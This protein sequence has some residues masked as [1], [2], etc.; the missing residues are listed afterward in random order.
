MGKEGGAGRPLAAGNV[1]CLGL[2]PSDVGVDIRKIHRA[3]HFRWVHRCSRRLEAYLAR[4]CTWIPA[5]T[6]CAHA[7]QTSCSPSH[8]HTAPRRMRGSLSEERDMAAIA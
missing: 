2:D 5:P 6:P 3:R 1:L 7:S 4:L 8:E